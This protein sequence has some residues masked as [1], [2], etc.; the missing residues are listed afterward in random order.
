MPVE[1]SASEK[2]APSVDRLFASA[3]EHYGQSLLGVVLT[4]MGNDGR[5]GALAIKEKGGRVIAESEETAVIFGMPQQ[6]I[7]AG[8][9]DEVVPLHAVPAAIQSAMSTD[10]VKKANGRG[11]E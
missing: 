7:R 8:A 9:V 11:S 1:S 10:G 3:A 2:Y 5:S 4:G 6:A